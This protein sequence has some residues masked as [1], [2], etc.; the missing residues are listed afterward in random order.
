MHECREN[1]KREDQSTL[2]L[3]SRSVRYVETALKILQR[4]DDPTTIT[5]GDLEALALVQFA[6]IAFLPN[7]YGALVVQGT[8]N[9]EVTKALLCFNTSDL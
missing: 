1:L 2:N 3:L 6:H 7:E 5:G 9:R 8:C 4:I